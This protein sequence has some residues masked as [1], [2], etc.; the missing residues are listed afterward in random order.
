MLNFQISKYKLNIHWGFI[1]PV[2]TK[3]KMLDTFKKALP[4]NN[5]DY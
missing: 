4:E 2:G 5:T 1:F 3:I